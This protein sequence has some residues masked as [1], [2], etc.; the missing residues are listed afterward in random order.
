M[1]LHRRHERDETGYGKVD[2]PKPLVGLAKY[3][4]EYQI[5]RLAEPK[6]PA[7]MC[8]WQ[9]LDQAIRYL[10]WHCVFVTVGISG[11]QTRH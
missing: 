6:D 3:S 5:H 10:H 1:G 7:S 8:A 11:P 9:A 2:V 4:P